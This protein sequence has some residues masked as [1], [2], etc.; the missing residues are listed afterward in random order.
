MGEDNIK[1]DLKAIEWDGVG[2]IRDGDKW[3][4]VVN[5]VTNPRIA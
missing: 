5:R 3:Q 4:T 1:M 2:W